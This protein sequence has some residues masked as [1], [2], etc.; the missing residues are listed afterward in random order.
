MSLWVFLAAFAGAATWTAASALYRHLR[1]PRPVVALEPGQRL[2]EPDG[3]EWL[4]VSRSFDMAVN[5]APNLTVSLVLDR[6]LTHADRS[7]R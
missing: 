4:V 5:R 2:A 7:P 6:D 1:Q 3:R